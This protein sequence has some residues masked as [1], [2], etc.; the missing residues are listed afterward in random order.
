MAAARYKDRVGNRGVSFAGLAPRARAD[1][2]DKAVALVRRRLCLY[3]TC[4]WH[5]FEASVAREAAALATQ[6]T[7]ACAALRQV[8]RLCD[9]A[10]LDRVLDEI[11]R[12]FVENRRAY[13]A[14]PAMLRAVEATMQVWDGIHSIQVP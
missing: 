8:L 9:D 12:L 4:A 5:T 2:A 11:D 13:T 1:A 6:G 3:E 10:P 7:D 14:T